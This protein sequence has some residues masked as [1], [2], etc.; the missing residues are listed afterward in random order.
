MDGLNPYKAKERDSNPMTTQWTLTGHH[1]RFYVAHKSS[2]FESRLNARQIAQR[3]H[4]ANF[5]KG[6]SHQ[7]S[8]LSFNITK[9]RLSKLLLHI[10][11]NHIM[12]HLNSPNIMNDDQ[13]SHNKRNS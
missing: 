5:Q 12:K 3:K 11:H 8:K 2:L 6:W 9:K 4:I 7:S 13:T 1:H 10:V